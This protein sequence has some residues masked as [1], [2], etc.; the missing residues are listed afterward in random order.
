MCGMFIYIFIYVFVG[1]YGCMF[2]V[3]N[4]ERAEINDE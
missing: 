1:V 3:P 2:M 4:R